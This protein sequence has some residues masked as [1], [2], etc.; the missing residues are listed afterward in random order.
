MVLFGIEVVREACGCRFRVLRLG[1]EVVR[2]ACGC[3]GFERLGLATELVLDSSNA[4]PCLRL[5]R[6]APHC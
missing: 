5:R 4:R 3:V 1:Y 2:E 6:L